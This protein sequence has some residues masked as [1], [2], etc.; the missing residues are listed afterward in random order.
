M[1]RGIVTDAPTQLGRISRLE[2]LTPTTRISL[3][4]LLEEQARDN[5][6]EVLYLYGDRAHRRG[7]VKTRIDN[8]V[9][10]L[11]EIGVRQGDRIGVLMG[12]RP[13][14][15]VLIAALNRLGATGVLLRPDGDLAREIAL[16]EVTRVVSDP[17]HLDARKNVD[18]VSWFLL[19]GGGEA[20]DIADDVVDMEQIDP[21]KVTVPSWYRPNPQRASDVA[22]VLFIGDGDATR[23]T[24]I[25]NR[26]WA[27][28]ALGTASAAN[29]RT[30]DTVY[31]VTPI[32]HSSALL[33]AVGGAVAGGS[34]LAM[35][36]GTDPQTF[37]DEVRRYGVTHVTY[38]WTSLLE[39]TDAPPN[40][41]EPHNPIRMFLGSGMPRSLWKR[42][43]ER[44]P[45]VRVLEFY[46]SI[47][48]SVILANLSGSKPGSLG[49]PLPGT[50]EVRVAAFDLVKQELILGA[51]GFAKE[52]LADE[53]GL[54]VAR[55][56]PGDV[57]GSEAMRSVFRADDAWRSTGDL[58]LRDQQGD[59]WCAGPAREVIQ[60]DRG[61]VVPA[62]VR[63][64]LGQLPGV[65]VT[66]AYG[67][68]DG[69]SDVVVGACT[70][71][72]GYTVDADAVNRVFGRLPKRLR[73]AYLQ[74]LDDIPIT[75]WGRPLWRPLQAA[76]VPKDRPGA[77]VFTLGEDLT[78]S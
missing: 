8:V 52:C 11:L 67:V 65:E 55:V 19:G 2:H 10:G 22:F 26:R 74:I 53:L 42:V 30:G 61:P 34:R 37:W 41:N 15:F 21:G 77:R 56:D 50:P 78:Y 75:T 13:S 20:R 35:A 47:E 16:G 24:T 32:Y 4:L 70:L 28:S 66:V 31:S 57:A 5:A 68:R 72:E 49:K 3:G 29:L 46:A 51:D 43:N 73:P 6:D 17:E 36:S 58:F 40:P 27:M 45:D 59:L 12:T 18:D 33:M 63:F 71:R 23:P 76:G 60:T 7:E 39:V 48:E 9:M 44:F 69:E 25:T 14:A 1:V 38:T 62:T 64:A 54:L